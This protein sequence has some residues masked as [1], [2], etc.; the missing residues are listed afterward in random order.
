MLLLTKLYLLISA[1]FILIP[2][3]FLFAIYSNRIIISNFNKAVVTVS[4]ILFV[5]LLAGLYYKVLYYNILK[6]TPAPSDKKRVPWPPIVSKCPD[7]WEDNGTNGSDCVNV[8]NLGTCRGPNGR[9][10]RMD[11]TGKSYTG[12]MG[13]CNK[14]NWANKCGV[15][16]EGVNKGA[17][18]P[19]T[20]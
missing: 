3:V 14:Y 19:C 7:Y 15:F 20:R 8:R 2:I 10:L 5:V 18:N 9:Q 13:A 4:C 12:T 6:G 17:P 16:W 11:F 1:L